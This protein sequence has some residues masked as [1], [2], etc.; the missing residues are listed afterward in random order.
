MDT[1]APINPY[2]T[3]GVEADADSAS[4]KKAYRKLVLT[5]HP[6]KVTD[7]SLRE[8]K[9]ELF[10]RIQ[11]AY[12]TI[13]EPDKRERY[14]AETK[15]KK[16]REE[17]DRMTPRSSPTQPRHF[18]VNIYTSGRR[19]PDFRGSSSKHSPS[20]RPSN[21]KPYSSDFSKSWEHDIPTRS[22]T[23]QEEPKT[24]RTASD[25]RLKRD[26]EDRSERERERERERRR[27]RDEEDERRRRRAHEIRE[28]ETRDRERDRDRARRAEKDRKDRE[29]RERAAGVRA[30]RK[31]RERLQ[32][33]EREIKRKQEAEEKVRAR[34]KSYA[35]PYIEDEDDLQRSRAKKASKKEMSARDKPSAKRSSPLEE[36]AAD[37]PTADKFQ[38]RLAFAASYIMNQQSKSSKS[39]K[40][41]DSAFSD[42]YPDPNNWNPAPRRRVSG[43]AKPAPA[44]EPVAP[45]DR[46]ADPPTVSPTTAP[47]P[48]RLQKSHTVSH[49][50]AAAPAAADPPPPPRIPL[51]RAHTMEPDYFG[52]SAGADSRHR[53]SRGRSSFDDQDE[54][55]APPP[56]PPPS[57]PKMQ[58]YTVSRD[59]GTPRVFESRHRDPYGPSPAAPSGAGFSK[60]KMSQPYGPDDVEYA[61]AS[62]K[63]PSYAEYNPPSAY[64]QAFVATHG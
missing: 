49:V 46:A 1:T 39:P 57:R 10:H 54:Y 35:E 37:Q 8:Q 59:G 12:E 44:D 20:K 53:P 23:F 56:P 4:I 32:E 30:E 38:S 13:G 15:L 51:G 64:T 2:K 55:Y 52:R 45:R 63:Q 48:P 25:E 3:L 50:P 26:A 58:K 40:H 6:D 17:R 11:Q 33:R 5:C 62:Y 60:V 28:K 43:D 19:S 9:Q 34:S 47:S 27:R 21:F 42:A 36:A 31:A 7:E 18:N 61:T 24:R 14:D 16:L 41:S 29:E 22:K